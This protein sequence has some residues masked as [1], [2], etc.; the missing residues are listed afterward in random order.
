MKKIVFYSLIA[1][2]LTS[3]QG[4]TVENKNVPPSPVQD[5]WNLVWSD[6]F[7]GNTVN[8]DNWNF[9]LWDAG[10]VNNEWQQYVE[11]T[12]YYKLEDGML[13]IKALKTGE[14]KKGGY[15]S[16][17]LNSKGKQEFKYGRIEFRAKMPASHG[18]GTWPALWMLGSNIDEVSWP[19]CG[20]I[21]IMEYV[22]Y[23]ADTTH[24]NVHTQYQH[25]V[26][27]FH[28]I[29]PLATAEE[30]FH[31]YGL[32]WTK[33]SIKFYL[34]SPDNITNVYAPEVKTEE[35]WPF[36]QP[37]YL[38]MNFAVGGVWGGKHGVDDTIFPQSMI[39]DY[40]RVY[41]PE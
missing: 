23:Q 20:E 15:T 18:K 37:F 33:D 24:S 30:E 40:V 36:D 11:D 29:T 19:K 7:D 5:G 4:K 25:G 14:N 41:Q 22:G 32:I 31:N 26:T 12:A 6:E 3:C 28:E 1:L 17:R 34:D 39:V 8:L 27:E 35:N 10:R 21:D 38:I 2:L 9:V 16:T 13:H